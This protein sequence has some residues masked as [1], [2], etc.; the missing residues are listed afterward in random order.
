MITWDEVGLNFLLE[1]LSG[2][3]CFS[4]SHYYDFSED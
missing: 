2:V 3:C 4:N 1:V